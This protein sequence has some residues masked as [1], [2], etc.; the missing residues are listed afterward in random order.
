MDSPEE[1]KEGGREGGR[2][3]RVGKMGEHA[4]FNP[5]NGMS[6]YIS[7]FSPSFPPSLPTEL[8]H[9]GPS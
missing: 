7:F 8:E 2:R 5:L 4:E 6:N 1:G 9:Q 3:R